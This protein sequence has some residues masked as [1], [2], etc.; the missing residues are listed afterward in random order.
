[1]EKS[2]KKRKVKK[3]SKTRRGRPELEEQERRLGRISVPVNEYEEA[4]IL[5]AASAVNMT[6]AGYLRHRGVGYRMP[7]PV[8]AINLEAH[9]GLARMAANL[10]K[11]VVLIHTGKCRGIRP[12]FVAQ[13]YEALQSVRRTLLEGQSDDHENQQG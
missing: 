2:K 5:R 13:V 10:N 6:K 4:E 3:Q 12:E 7:R 8:P 11:L 9:R 1:M